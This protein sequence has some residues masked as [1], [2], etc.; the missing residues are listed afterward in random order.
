MAKIMLHIMDPKGV[1][2]GQAEMQYVRSEGRKMVLSAQHTL[3]KGTLGYAEAR[4]DGAI[5]G[6]ARFLKYNDWAT[7]P[8]DPNVL[9]VNSLKV[10]NGYSFITNNFHITTDTLRKPAVWPADQGVLLLGQ[11]QTV[12]KNNN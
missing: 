12:G 9:N 6:E 11:V 8:N 1:Q 4:I 2:L 5:V 10:L 7:R 3:T